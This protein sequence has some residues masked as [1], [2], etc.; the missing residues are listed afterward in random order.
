MGIL[1]Y[2]RM[3][4]KDKGT[5][6]GAA[7]KGLATELT[8]AFQYSPHSHP[9]Q[10]VIQGCSVAAKSMALPISAASESS[11]SVG[12]IPQLNL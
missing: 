8:P 2:I 6:N 10:F 12:N 3:K 1:I 4:V 9:I 11:A 7:T 5:I